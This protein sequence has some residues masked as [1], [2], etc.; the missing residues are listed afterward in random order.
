MGLQVLAH[1][2]QPLAGPD[3]DADTLGGLTADVNLAEP[4]GA[5]EMRQPFGIAR[6]GLVDPPRE[7]LVRKAGVDADD[8]QTA[9]LQLSRQPDGQDTTLMN[10]PIRIG[11]MFCNERSDLIGVR[12]GVSSG[13]HRSRGIHHADRNGFDGHVE[14][15]IM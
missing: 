14:A 7:G 11:R 5:R 12:G 6:V 1:P 4:A 9:L 15:Y 8:R 2:D 10:N 13:E 3:Q